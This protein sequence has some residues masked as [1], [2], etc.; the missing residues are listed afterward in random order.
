M[1]SMIFDLDDT[2]YFQKEQFVKATEKNSLRFG[3]VDIDQLYEQFQYF[4]ERAYFMRERGELSFQD[5]RVQRIQLAYEA[6]GIVLSHENCQLWQRDYLYEQNHISLSPAVVEILNYCQSQSMEIGIITNGPSDHQRM[7]L[8]SLG[9]DRWFSPEQILVSGDIGFSKPDRQVFDLMATRLKG[10]PRYYIG[11]N[12]V[13][14]VQG[15]LNAGWQVI[16]LN[17]KGESATQE[18]V[19]EVTNH[20]NLLACIKEIQT[21]VRLDN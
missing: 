9:L 14:D 21:N 20:A 7:K 18:E 10:N 17:T 6:Q 8:E 4:S 13:N 2:L 19:I 5:M 11:D 12:P 1:I 3:E 16:W 15:A